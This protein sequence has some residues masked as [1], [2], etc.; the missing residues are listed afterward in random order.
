MFLF[1]EPIH[2]QIPQFEVL[3]NLKENTLPYYYPKT[4]FFGNGKTLMTP[5]S[6]GA[7]GNTLFIGGGI[8]LRQVYANVPDGAAVVGIGFGNPFKLLGVELAA[9][10]NDLSEQ[11]NFSYSFKLHK[12]IYNGTS[13]AIGAN[14]LFYDYTQ[15]DATSSFYACISHAIQGLPSNVPGRSRLNLNAGI[16]FG[17]YSEKSPKDI[18][19]GKGTKGTYIFGSVAYQLFRGNSL[20]VEWSGINLNVGL[21]TRPLKRLPFFF[22]I[23]VVDLTKYS[24][25]GPRVVISGVC[26]LTFK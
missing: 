12:Y 22:K 4:L 3:P 14:H 1:G 5:A 13:I 15:T 8:A 9:K 21:S 11:N 25:D 26:A 7:Y 19:E 24:G 6:F 20:I 18:A 23:G 10:M 17:K 2:S 16:G